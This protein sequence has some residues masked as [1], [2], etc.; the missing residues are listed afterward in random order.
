MITN[1][2]S[3]MRVVETLQDL[4]RPSGTIGILSSGQGSIT[5]NENGNHEVYRGSKAAFNMFM[6]SFA[7]RHAD[8]P[9]TL[10]LPRAGCE[11]IWEAPK[12]V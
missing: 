11:R 9:R 1:A 6:R 7:A 12:H 2:L 5:N 8:D 4:V 10:L 3:P